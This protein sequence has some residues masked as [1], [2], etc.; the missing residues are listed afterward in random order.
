MEMRLLLVGD[1]VLLLQGLAQLLQDQ[2]GAQVRTAVPPET[3]AAAL[4]DWRPDLV[5]TETAD[6]L[7]AAERLAHLCRLA[8][9]IPLVVIAPSEPAQ[10]LAALRAGARGFVGRDVPADRLYGC[11]AAVQRGEWGLPRALLGA[12]VEAY[13]DLSAD[14][15]PPVPALTTREQHI[16]RLLAQGLSTPRIGRQLYL[17]ESTVRAEI[18]TLSQK[19][20]VANRVQLVS[21]ALR[22]GLVPAEEPQPAHL[23]GITAPA[24][25][26]GEPRDG[27]RQQV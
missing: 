13:V 24:R 27:G 22:R 16:L 23:N 20:G 21:E 17:S 11:L 14:A 12:L 8:D 2:P 6:V 19:L 26:A 5:L 7:A 4:R 10:F 15:Q 18:R 25:A 1:H 9:A 3:A